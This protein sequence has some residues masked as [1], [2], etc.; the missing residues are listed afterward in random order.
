MSPVGP[1]RIVW[2][3]VSYVIGWWIIAVSVRKGSVRYPVWYHCYATYMT[4]YSVHPSWV[5]HQGNF[6]LHQVFLLFRRWLWGWG[7]MCVESRKVFILSRQP[8]SEWRMECVG[9]MECLPCR[10]RKEEKNK[11]VQQPT[12]LQWWSSMFWVFKW[13]SY[14]Y[15]R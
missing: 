8:V 10:D 5:W 6:S 4:W 1:I 14:M 13:R 12:T 7:G 15:Y 9:I 2:G 3:M 11:T